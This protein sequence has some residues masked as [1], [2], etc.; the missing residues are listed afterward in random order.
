METINNFFTNLFSFNNYIGIIVNVGTILGWLAGIFWLIKSIIRRIKRKKLLKFA[1][2]SEGSVA[3]SIGVG[4]NPKEAVERFL[5]KNYKDVPLLMDYSKLGYFSEEDILKIFEEI[6][7]FLF[8][9]KQRGDVEE[10]LLFYGGPVTLMAPIGAILYNSKTTKIFHNDIK[11]KDY[12]LHF[13]LDREIIK[14]IPP[15]YREKEYVKD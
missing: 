14:S 5:E 2:S 13:T 7:L 4:I 6:K 10:I 9:I 1:P 3:V 15:K 8:D 11:K 12:V